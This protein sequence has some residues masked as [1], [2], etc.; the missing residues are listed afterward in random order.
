M[1]LIQ[2]VI[3]L[4]SKGNSAGP[5][6]RAQYSDDC[7]NYTNTVGTS[8]VNLPNIGSQV[9]VTYPDTAICLRLVNQNGSCDNNFVVQIIG[10]TTTTSTTSTTS[11]STTST[12][13][14]PPTTTTTTFSNNPCIC[15]EVN[16]T[17][18]GGEVATFNCFGQNQNYVYLTAGTR[19]I[20]A[21]EIGGLL[22]ADIVSGTGTISPNGNCKTGPCPPNTTTSTTTL[23]PCYQNFTFQ[24]TNAGSFNWLT[25]YGISDGGYYPNG[26]YTIT[27]CIQPETFESSDGGTF[28]VV[29]F[30]TPCT[31]TT[32]TSTTST[33]T[34]APTT[35]T[36]TTLSNC[37]SGVTIEVTSPG[38]VTY[39]DCYDVSQNEY[40]PVGPNVIPGCI[41]GQTISFSDAEGSVTSFGT[42]CTTTTSTS[43]STTSTTTAAG[44]NLDWT[45]SELN[46]ANGTMDINVNGIA[47]ESRSVNSNGTITG[48][49]VGDEIQIDINVVGCSGINDFANA[50]SYGIIADG[51][52]DES[53]TFYSSG[54][55]VVTS[56]DIGTTLELDMFAACDGGCV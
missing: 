14:A 7:I 40:Y 47:V 18:E 2:R 48:L 52:C 50:Y 41:K 22:Q 4:T 33:T 6:F 36:T 35:T 43:T 29:T 24:V 34:I 31:T 32:S 21:A 26:E 13:T 53:V 17:S 11:T 15:T 42:P 19:Y 10:T 51:T 39:L 27:G 30:G 37:Q 28:T 54:V 23:A 45:F 16:I 8:L 38:N 56:G 55:Y 25:C 12:T 5:S 44:A 49:Q 9:T 3:T 1:A 46:G 20:C